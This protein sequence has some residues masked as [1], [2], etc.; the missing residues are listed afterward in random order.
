MEFLVGGINLSADSKWIL[1]GG[2]RATLGRMRGNP[3]EWR[4]KAWRLLGA[5]GW[6]GTGQRLVKAPEN[7]HLNDQ[8]K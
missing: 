4:M 1:Q 5:L 6:R 8:N 2:W 7:R 3:M